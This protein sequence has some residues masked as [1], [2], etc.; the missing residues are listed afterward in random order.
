MGVA[1]RRVPTEIYYLY[2]LHRLDQLRH[3]LGCPHRSLG[4]PGGPHADGTT[5]SLVEVCNG[6][7]NVELAGSLSKI[8]RAVDAP[9]RSAPVAPTPSESAP[10]SPRASLSLL[11]EIL[12]SQA[13][14]NHWTPG[15]R[16]RRSYNVVRRRLLEAAR[17]IAVRRRALYRRLYIP[18]AFRETDRAAIN[19]ELVQWL[20]LLQRR[21]NRQPCGF[22]GGLLRTLRATDEGAHFLRLAHFPRDIR[23][24]RATF[25]RLDRRLQQASA[26]DDESLLF[27]FAV[28]CLDER[29]GH[30]V[31]I[32][33]A[34]LSLNREYL[35]V[36]STE[37][38][39]LI[40][41][42]IEGHR[43]FRR[44]L[45]AE[46]I[47]APPN[48]PMPCAI[49]E[50]RDDRLC[51]EIFPEMGSA[52]NAERWQQRR[53]VYAAEGQ[54][55]WWWDSHAMIEP[56]EIPRPTVSSREPLRASGE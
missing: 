8:H 21:G 18:P 41:M 6:Y 53:S 24:D 30:L 23:L 4:S 44:P 35:P 39:V 20:S 25:G 31:A 56:P 55:V 43:R 29:T 22:V 34:A 28:T 45:D 19:A 36:G 48:T 38:A 5:R 12:W 7:V 16:G 3:A 52:A 40:E 9:A 32:D 46:Y 54:A 14:L 13:A 15:F 2:P 17:L 51:L 1:H 50:D 27:V 33:V 11:A 26:Y 37:E 47:H 49:L 42:L 10:A